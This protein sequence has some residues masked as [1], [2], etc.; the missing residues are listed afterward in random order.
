MIRVSSS[1]ARPCLLLPQTCRTRAPARRTTASLPSLTACRP[2]DRQAARVSGAAAA[3][4]AFGTAGR[5]SDTDTAWVAFSSANSCRHTEER[6]REHAQG[7]LRFRGPRVEEGGRKRYLVDV[8]RA[9]APQ[10][11]QQLVALLASERVPVGKHVALPH[12]E[13]AS[14]MSRENRSRAQHT[15]GQRPRT[16]PS[17]LA[18]SWWRFSTH[19][20]MSADATVPSK[21]R[22]FAALQRGWHRCQ[23][24][25][26]AC[27]HALCAVACH[28]HTARVT[29]HVPAAVC[30][31]WRQQAEPAAFAPLPDVRPTRRVHRAGGHRPERQEH[32]VR[33]PG[34]VTQRSRRAC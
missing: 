6:E 3:T 11:R 13:A 32:P 14:G 10:L 29:A 16:R 17:A 22:A 21:E 19:Q 31:V 28:P 20:C 15:P 7:G 23:H 30:R 24:S 4:L 25:A 8:C 18:R 27:V 9:D 5:R 12:A 2:T 1:D 33:P 34:H 26:G